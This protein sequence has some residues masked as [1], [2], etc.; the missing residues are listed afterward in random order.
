MHPNVV[1][2]TGIAIVVV[3]VVG[4]VAGGDV[5]VVFVGAGALVV[6]FVGAGALAAATLAVVVVAA[7]TVVTEVVVPPPAN[8]VADPIEPPVGDAA[9]CSLPCEWTGLEPKPGVVTKMTATTRAK[10]VP[11]II[12]CPRLFRVRIWCG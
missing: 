5:V 9:A 2:V 4:A 3:V 8:V 1:V 7:G 10:T 11:T 12:H 6:V